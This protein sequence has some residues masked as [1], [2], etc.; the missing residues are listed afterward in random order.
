M[1]LGKPRDPRK[2]QQWRRWIQLWQRSGLTIRAFCDEQ[3]L[4]EPSFHA[5]RRL[6]RQ[7]EAATTTAPF[8]PVHVVAD[9]PDVPDRPGTPL[10]ILLPGNRILRVAPGFDAATLRQLLAV[11]REVPGC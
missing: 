9:H 2:E 11:L 8:L 7:R 6:I 1:A 5:W 10:E 3:H 4:S